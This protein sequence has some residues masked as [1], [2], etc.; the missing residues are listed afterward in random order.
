VNLTLRITKHRSPCAVLSGLF[1]D[2]VAPLQKPP[3]LTVTATE[4]ARSLASRYDKLITGS[5]ESLLNVVEGEKLAKFERDCHALLDEHEDTQLLWYLAECARVRGD[6]VSS[7]GMLVKFLTA[8][9]D[10]GPE[11]RQD[12]L[13]RRVGREFAQVGYRPEALMAVLEARAL[14]SDKKRDGHFEELAARHNTGHV[15]RIAK[16]WDSASPLGNE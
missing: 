4:A 8:V 6:Y 11:E 3:D 14:V 9:R 2:E 7:Q 1:L 15:R 13:F 16:R 12:D 5:K 10:R